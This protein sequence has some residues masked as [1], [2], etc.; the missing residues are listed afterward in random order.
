MPQS[1]A[2]ETNKT[3]LTNL[4]RGIVLLTFASLSTF[5]RCRYFTQYHVAT[6]FVLFIWILVRFDPEFNG[7]LRLALPIC[8]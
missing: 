2:R 7:L 4:I 8:F 5:V 6:F 3:K 1:L